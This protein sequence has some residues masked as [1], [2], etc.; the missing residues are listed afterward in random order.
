MSASRPLF[1]VTCSP[2]CVG[3]LKRNSRGPASAA[4][5][6]T[7][8]VADSPS[9]GSVTS[10]VLTIRPSSSTV[11]GTVWPPYPVC[12]STTSTTSAV[13]FS[14]VRGVSTRV[15]W[16]SWAKCSRPTP[17]VN[18]GI[19]RALRLASVSSIAASEVSAPSLIMTRP[20]SG[21]PDSSSRARSSAGARRVDVP[22]NLRSAADAPRSDDEAKRK[23][24]ITKRCDSASSSFAFGPFICCW[25]NA[26]RAWPSTSAIDMLRESSTSTP[27]KFCCGT[28]AL[29]ISAGRKRQN[30][31]TARAAS[32]RPRSKRRREGGGEPRG[33]EKDAIARG[34]GRRHA[35]IG[36]ERQHGE[37]GGGGDQEENRARQSPGTVPL[38]KHEG[39]VLEQE[40]ESLVDHQALILIL[41]RPAK[42]WKVYDAGSGG[43]NSGSSSQL[44]AVRAGA[45]APAASAA[46]ASPA[47]FSPGSFP[48]GDACSISALS[49][50][51]TSTASADR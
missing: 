9:A 26:L 10:C 33:E 14:A 5:K 49:S 46:C 50:A 7:L 48:S 22:P 20:A 36:E 21:S 3:T 16:T 45:G 47:T 6:R 35:A 17:T 29:R 2:V 40:P 31:S 30:S 39:R 12:V 23:K 11:S 42:V 13:P 41:E 51:P 28:A 8:T 18:T 44:A 43:G 34:S 25:T 19:D 15:T 32:R 37:R 38:L 4:V 1:C 27:R 24:R